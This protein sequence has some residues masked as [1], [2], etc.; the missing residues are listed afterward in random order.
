MCAFF[1]C[2]LTT[3][4]GFLPLT[5]CFVSQI[6]DKFVFSGNLCNIIRGEIIE[7]CAFSSVWFFSS[8]TLLSFTCEN[9]CKAVNKKLASLLLLPVS[10]AKVDAGTVTKCNFAG[11]QKAGASW[12]DKIMANKAAAA[13]GQTPGGQGDGGEDGE[14]VRDSHS[15]EKGNSHTR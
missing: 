4:A 8:S 1:R 9:S 5:H 2:E 11:D 10:L 6:G 12:T 7:F 3:K 14:W 15:L 13:D